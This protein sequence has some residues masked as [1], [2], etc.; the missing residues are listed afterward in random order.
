MIRIRC[1]G[2]DGVREMDSEEGIPLLTI[3][4]KNG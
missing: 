3:L 1:I 2:S 4:G